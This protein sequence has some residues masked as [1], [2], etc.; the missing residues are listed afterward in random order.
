MVD[1]NTHFLPKTYEIK[2]LDIDFVFVWL[3]INRTFI[4]HGYATLHH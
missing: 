3:G 2:H 4:N 1:R